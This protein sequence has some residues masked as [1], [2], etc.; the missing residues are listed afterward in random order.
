MLVA[1]LAR[2]NGKVGERDLD[3]LQEWLRLAESVA[4]SLLPCGHR[5]GCRPL[6]WAVEWLAQRDLERVTAGTMDPRGTAEVVS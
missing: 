1:V 6:G 2:L 5:L 4:V 3:A